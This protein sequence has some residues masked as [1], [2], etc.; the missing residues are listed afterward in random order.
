MLPGQ[1][2]AIANFGEAQTAAATKPLE[3]VIK[4]NGD[5]PDLPRGL[6]A[7][8]TG[9]IDRA[10]GE[11]GPV[12]CVQPAGIEQH[13]ICAIAATFSELSVEDPTTGETLASWTIG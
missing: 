4:R 9:R 11:A 5:A 12:R 3:A 10:P 6:R 13:P 1:T 8:V 7:R 2:L